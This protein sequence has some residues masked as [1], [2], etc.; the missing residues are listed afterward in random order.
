MTRRPSARSARFA[1]TWLPPLLLLL[2]TGA[3][4]L[5][6]LAAGF[7]WDD[8]SQVRDNPY[9]RS[10]RWV[11]EIF[12]RD[13]WITS[14]SAEFSGYYR[15]LQN[16]S[17]ALDYALW[18]NRPF[19]FHLTN[20][21]LHLAV[22][23][24]LYGLVRRQGF[25][26]PAAFVFAAVFAVHPLHVEE[27]TFIGG[28]GG[29]LSAVF[30]FGGLAWVQHA[31]RQ[32]ARL[33]A[34][35]T[36]A[37]LSVFLAFLAKPLA[38]LFPVVLAAAPWV[39]TAAESTAV[40]IRRSAGLLV[41]GGLAAGA[42]FSI[43]YLFLQVRFGDAVPGSSLSGALVRLPAIVT[44]YL[45]KIFFPIGLAI[46]YPPPDYGQPP[47][48][49]ALFWIAL[50]LLPL[51]I[52]AFGLV[53]GR[54][55]A[56]WL[57]FAP[58]LLCPL[59]GLW[60]G[61]FVVADRYAYLP[62]AALGALLAWPLEAA[63]ENLRRRTAALS[64]AMIPVLAFGVLTIARNNVFLNQ[65]TFWAAAERAAPLRPKVVEGVA[66]RLA[67]QGRL[68]ETIA[69]LEAVTARLPDN[70]NLRLELAMY[71]FDAG[72]TDESQRLTEAVVREKPHLAKALWH[73]SQLS[74]AR[75]DYPTAL[76]LT[77]RLLA[78]NPRDL[79]AL[80]NL[81]VL[82]KLADQPQQALA[83]LDDVLAQSPL[84]GLANLYKGMMLFEAGRRREA[85]VF[86]R[87]GLAANPG[88]AKAQEMLREAETG[89]I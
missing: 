77:R 44:A 28:R 56:F 70:A 38:L 80:V 84:H 16:L 62:V 31:L 64:L 59:A 78:E 29:L 25:G 24:L 53:H 7:V 48:W 30:L 21:L 54:R 71:L 82:L 23:L 20:L 4:Y 22:C 41:A 19:G 52:A 33:F 68:A 15:P 39:V 3:C 67:R 72:R 17:Y 51:A 75:R 40:K 88:H 61:Y 13:L 46:D 37:F 86:L 36:A 27:A 50:I 76:R 2:L 45:V 60:S 35:A 11:P 89:G 81:A 49:I 66:A 1:A 34:P 10:L 87:Q 9:L 8:L 85:I 63:G 83:A 79:D 5:N 47:A 58:L 65:D 6:A 26:P 12:T 57:L 69:Y 32:S 55:W 74:F 43:P 73:L 14:G 18:G 42:A